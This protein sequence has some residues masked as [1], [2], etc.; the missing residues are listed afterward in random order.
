MARP[1]FAVIVIAAGADQ[2]EP[3]VRSVLNQPER[4]LEVIV[5]APSQSQA[6]AGCQALAARDRR[7]QVLA[8]DGER[9]PR[10]GVAL[11]VSASALLEVLQR[12]RSNAVML[13]DGAVDQLS[14]G[15][16]KDGRVVLNIGDAVVGARRGTAVGD[17]NGS[18]RTAFDDLS[19][20]TVI[21][22][23]ALWKQTFS[24]GGKRVYLPDLSLDLLVRSRHPECLGCELCQTR[25]RPQPKEEAQAQELLRSLHHRARVLKLLPEADRTE[26]LGRTLAGPLIKLALLCGSLPSELVAEAQGLAASLVPPSAEEPLSSLPLVDRVLLHALAHRERVD[27][28]E[29][30]VARAREGTSV[31]LRFYGDRL[32]VTL[33]VLERLEGLPGSLLTPQAADSCAFAATHGLRVVEDGLEVTGRAYLYGVRPQDTELQL[34]LVSGHGDAQVLDWSPCGAPQADLYANDPWTSYVESGFRAVIPVD[35]LAGEAQIRVRLRAADHELSTWLPAPP[36]AVGRCPGACSGTAWAWWPGEDGETCISLS[37]APQPSDLAELSVIVAGA[38]LLGCKLRLMLQ[39]NGGQ[40]TG[41]EAVSSHGTVPFTLTEEGG[42]LSAVVDL[43]ESGLA[44]GGHR[45]RWLTADQQGWCQAA[46]DLEVA[47]LKLL[48]TAHGARLR[49]AI[50]GEAV[51]T[52]TAPLTVFE[53]SAYGRQQLVQETFGPLVDAVLFESFRGRST[54]DNPGAIFQD[55]KEYGVNVPLWWSVEDGAAP[56]GS[57]PVVT[58]SC[59]WF[60][61]LRT[62]RVIVTN[63]N[64][65]YWFRKQPGQHV[66]QTWHG[67]TVKHLLRDA[68]GQAVSLPYRHLMAR[69]VSQWD[70]LLAQTEQAGQ[71]LCSAMGY[72]GK[73]L[74]GEYPRNVG[75]LGGEKVRLRAR[76]ALGIDAA[77]KVLLYAP[78]WREALRDGPR[79]ALSLFDPVALAASTGVTVLVRSHHMNELRADGV[80]VVDVSQYPNAEGLMLA[81]DVLVSD[82]SSIVFDWALTGKPCVLHVPDLEEYRQERG[83]YGRWPDDSGLPVSRNQAE[84]TDAVL[85]ALAAPVP[86]QVPDPEPVH[87]TLKR[88][89]EWIT[90]ALGLE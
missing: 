38:S 77:T 67:S 39:T 84:L 90:E 49:A 74:V 69:Q 88:V 45:L 29:L 70:L 41:L 33:P 72:E 64:L 19:P 9:A 20:A 8:L 7:I 73:V 26:V 79:S 63:D 17:A 23:K 6:A 57:V 75:L 60:R 55:F 11:S 3:T 44:R 62:A 32:R 86:A 68:P 46:P 22:S 52:L 48:G 61:A 80:G 47:T 13:L 16:L 12:A 50:G 43:Q 53:Q 89:R 42:T 66:L 24:S 5:V 21:A 28:E 85:A 81:A 40:L 27:L 65:P 54:A 36:Q 18:A 10:R 78:T 35:A 30:L 25:K 37:E 76:R 1:A 83:L 58:G 31:P 15:V 34:E 4:D 51:L 87:Q 56:R 14:S 82:Y 59:Q 2:V 71:R